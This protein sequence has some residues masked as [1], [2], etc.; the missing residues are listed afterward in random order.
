M[1]FEELSQA[2][3]Q[4]DADAQAQLGRL[5]IQRHYFQVGIHYMLESVSQ[6]KNLEHIFY[7]NV[8]INNVTSTEEKRKI[9]RAFPGADY[10]ICS[11]PCTQEQKQFIKEELHEA[12]KNRYRYHYTI[13]G[14]PFLLFG[15]PFYQKNHYTC[16]SYAAELL[17][18]AGV[19]TWN[20]H[21]SLVTPK[22]FYEYKGKQKIFE[23]SL[24]ELTEREK[25]TY[26]EYGTLTFPPISRPAY[27]SAAGNYITMAHVHNVREEERKGRRRRYER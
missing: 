9:L 4:G 25:K 20:K 6:T 5:L 8:A 24:R 14:L 12:M 23:G 7:I 17:E 10:M 15:K 19:C 27:L 3:K 2:A 18:K 26:P 21:F 22:D 13:L 16:S 1:T 11:I